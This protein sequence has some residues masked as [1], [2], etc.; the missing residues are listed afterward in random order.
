M[1]ATTKAAFWGIAC[2]AVSNIKAGGLLDIEECSNSIFS[3]LHAASLKIAAPNGRF[4][5]R[6]SFNGIMATG[7]GEAYDYGI[8]I[9]N[10]SNC[11]ISDARI[12]VTKASSDGIRITSNDDPGENETVFDNV[13]VETHTRYGVYIVNA[14]SLANSTHR[15]RGL[16]VRSAGTYPMIYTSGSTTSYGRLIIESSRVVGSPQLNRPLYLRING[17]EIVGNYNAGLQTGTSGWTTILDDLL[18]SRSS[19]GTP[20]ISVNGATDVAGL[21]IG[22]VRQA[23]SGG[24]SVFGTI[25]FASGVKAW[26][27]GPVVEA[28]T[29]ADSLGANVKE[30]SM[31]RLRGN[32]TNWGHTHN[33]TAWVAK[34]H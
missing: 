7:A 21:Y 18:F 10:A 2:G 20:T 15:F 5:R 11:Y 31:Y 9:H 1:L 29:W 32:T 4:V 12:Y 26:I 30:G 22:N 28:T 19:A 6:C 23:L 24:W 14:A 25:T 33:G 34:T 8:H 16:D 13:R 27:D 3:N 17:L